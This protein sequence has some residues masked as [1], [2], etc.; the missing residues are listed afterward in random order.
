MEKEIIIRKALEKDHDLIWEI[1]QPVIAAGDTYVFA[2]DSS[3]KK[4][5][6]YW[7]GEDKYTYVALIGSKVAGTFI[8][9]D[10]FPDLGSHVANASYMTH[11][12]CAGQGVG[13]AMG[14]FSL[15]EAGK[16]GY[17]AIQFNIVVKSN[18]RAIGLWEQLGFEIIG[19]IPEAF[20]HPDKGLVNAYIMWK[21]L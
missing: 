21:A 20:Q 12:D 9:K 14:R 3:K 11:P 16:L 19:E 10:N 15:A 6:E 17:R 13:K 2:P 1:I 8:L 5:L 7:C 4:M 18:E